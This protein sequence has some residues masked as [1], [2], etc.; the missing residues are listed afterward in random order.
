M[1]NSTPWLV[2]RP[3][4]IRPLRL[5]CFAYA[6]GHAGVFMPWQAALE[7]HIEVCAVQLPGR[8]SRMGEAPMTSIPALVDRIAEVIASQDERPFAFF[9]HSLGALL[10]FEI[11]R[12]RA[13][14]GLPAPVHLFV[15]GC[16]APTHRGSP[17]NLHL[18][19]DAQLLDEI[20]GY[21][22][23]PP[24][25]L[26]NEELMELIL[27]VMR[28]DFALEPGYVYEPGPPLAMP[29][30][31]L[32]GSQDRHGLWKEV[33]RWTEQTQGH[34]RVQ[35]FDGDHFFINARQQDVI[36]CVRSELLG[37]RSVF[38]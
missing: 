19:S 32:A 6:G 38:V 14:N 23:T 8:G 10:A 34:G 13:R 15:S 33:G 1:S 17:K 36:D 31:V 28:V 3:G 27:S 2:S 20:K 12:H 29:M 5:Y 24:E 35:W 37:S 18:L 4:P 7:P 11:A 16:E 21:N 25:V 30:T 26:A 9:G 22:G